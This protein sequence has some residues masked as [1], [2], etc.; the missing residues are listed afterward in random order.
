MFCLGLD[1]AADVGD[2]SARRLLAEHMHAL[3]QAG[4]RYVGCDVVG[5]ADEQGVE[6]LSQKF[7]RRTEIGNAV[8]K[9]PIAVESPVA[10]G[11]GFQCRMRVDEFPPTLA[12]N[13]VAGDCD[14]QGRFVCGHV[15]GPPLP[16]GRRNR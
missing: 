5:H 4:N 13:A 2:R 14:V 1:H 12:D 10:D 8:L 9:L 7:V 11:D 16:A 15:C 6:V 3:F